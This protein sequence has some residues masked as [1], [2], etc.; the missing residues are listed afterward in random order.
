[1]NK[2]EEMLHLILKSVRVWPRNMC[3]EMLETLT[4][5]QP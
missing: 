5:V 4:I 3:N 2:K 1:M